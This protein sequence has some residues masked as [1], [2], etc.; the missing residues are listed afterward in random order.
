VVVW[1]ADAEDWVDRSVGDVIAQ[2]ARHLGPGGI[3]LLHERLEPD[4]LRG[5]PA[6]TFDRLGMVRGIG[7]ACRSRGLQMNT[8]TALADAHGVVSTAWFRP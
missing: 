2:G 5:A 7:E 1:S 3:L 6:T 4:P 8:I